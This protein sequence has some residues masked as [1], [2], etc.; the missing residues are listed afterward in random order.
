MLDRVLR[1]PAVGSKRYLTNKVRNLLV[2]RVPYR[3]LSSVSLWLEKGN[4]PDLFTYMYVAIWVSI[5]LTALIMLNILFPI[6]LR[7]KHGQVDSVFA[8]DRM[9]TIY[10]AFQSCRFHNVLQDICCQIGLADTL[11]LN[12]ILVSIQCQT[13]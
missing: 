4:T 2:S 10:V 6:Q 12:L 5:T 11:G 8:L 7:G 1:L 3:F 9:H 13:R